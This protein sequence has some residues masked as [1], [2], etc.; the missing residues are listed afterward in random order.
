MCVFFISL[1]LSL[2]LVNYSRKDNLWTFRTGMVS[3]EWFSI[4]N[5]KYIQNNNNN[6]LCSVTLPILRKDVYFAY[7]KINTDVRH[8]IITPHRICELVTGV[9]LSNSQVQQR[10]ADTPLHSQTNCNDTK[11]PRW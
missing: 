10:W 8:K 3:S 7:I 2:N 9:H 4:F 6:F 11:G 1:T 5:K